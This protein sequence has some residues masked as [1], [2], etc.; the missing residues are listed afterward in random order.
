MTSCVI[1][2]VN[3][4]MKL[5]VRYFS[6][7]EKHKTYTYFNISTASKLIVSLFLNTAVIPVMV[8]YKK[9][10]WFTG[11]GLCMDVFFNSLALSFVA[12]FV[13]VFFDIEYVFKKLMRRF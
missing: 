7:F 6:K 9:E 2:I 4:I 1:V 11:A 3:A 5:A 8:N 12:P 13:Y 10:E